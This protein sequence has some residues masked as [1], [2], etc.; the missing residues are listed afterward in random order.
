MGGFIVKLKTPY[1]LFLGDEKTQERAK[2]AL[3]LLEWAPEK[4]AGQWRLEGS[5]VDL[6]LDELT[7]SDFVAKHGG[8]TLVIGVTNSGGFLP[9]CWIEPL[10]QALEAGLDLAAGLHVRLNDIPQLKELAG[11]CNR[12]LRDVRYPGRTV[13]PGSG[14]KRSGM[15]LLTVGADCAIGKKYAALAITKELQS[16]GCNADFRATG[17]TGILISGTG[18][19]VDSVVSDFVSGAAES[20]SPDNV[21]DH[22]DVIEGQGSLFHPSYAGVALGLLHGSQPDALVICHDPGRTHTAHMG[23]SFPLPDIETVM[24]RNIEAAQL[25]NPDVKVLGISVNTSGMAAGEANSCMR[26]LKQHTGL[27]VCDPVR[28]GMAEIVDHLLETG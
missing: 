1:L 18:I 26:A 16:R 17:Q 21:E 19:A 23:E 22:W 3:G 20:I 10:C 24:R 4:C 13:K 28:T 6:G 7:P 5:G 2:T 25:T 8:G 14:I 15:R 27:P 11:R 9:D 12:R